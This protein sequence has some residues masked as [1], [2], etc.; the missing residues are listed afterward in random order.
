[1]ETRLWLH[2]LSF[3]ER[4]QETLA[5]VGQLPL[6]KGLVVKIDGTPKAWMPCDPCINIEGVRQALQRRTPI[7]FIDNDALLF[8]YQLRLPDPY[9]AKKLG[10][11]GYAEIYPMPCLFEI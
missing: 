4:L 11:D 9:L 7:H 6:V 5:G 3:P 2:S 8:H 1:M 10:V